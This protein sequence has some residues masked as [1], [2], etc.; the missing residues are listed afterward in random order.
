[1]RGSG[2]GVVAS[3][4]IPPGA[5]PE[6]AEAQARFDQV[7]ARWAERA[8]E[9]TDAEAAVETA[10]EKDRQAAVEAALAGKDL[11]G[12]LSKNESDALVKAD[13]LKRTLPALEQALDEAGNAL[14]QAIAP[15][16]ERWAAGLEVERDEAAARYLAAVEE[17]QTA[18]D[19]LGKAESARVWLVDFDEG[20]A[21][22][23]PDPRLAWQGGPPR[24]RGPVRPAGGS[25]GPLGAGRG[26]G[27]AGNEG[28]AQGG[29]RGQGPRRARGP[30]RPVGGKGMSGERKDQLA[31][32]TLPG[33]TPEEIVKARKDGRLSELLA[34]AS[35]ASPSSSR[36]RARI[37]APAA[38]GRSRAPA[39][40]SLPYR[41]SGSWS[42]TARAS[43]TPS[44]PESSGE[45]RGA[46]AGR[47]H[48]RRPHPRAALGASRPAAGNRSRRSPSQRR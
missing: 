16:A 7:A 44:L 42:C 31:G 46:A 26:R 27:A 37:R 47:L 3:F 1:M 19:E 29:A 12:D 8:G 4:T 2:R 33:M 18:L 32:Y 40:G 41:P 36:L 24:S 35:P 15:V 28:A 45:I 38:V 17:A 14:A 34:V 25:A 22:G 10:R 39:P 48:A 20:I 43:P 9:L 6:V 23:R 11:D 30:A 5:P 13:A 21:R